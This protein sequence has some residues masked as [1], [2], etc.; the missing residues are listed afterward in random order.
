MDTEIHSE[1]PE[2]DTNKYKKSKMAWQY[3]PPQ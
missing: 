1:Q 2:T 3:S